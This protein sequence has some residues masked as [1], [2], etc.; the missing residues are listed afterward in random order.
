MIPSFSKT[1]GQDTPELPSTV[2]ATN[3]TDYDLR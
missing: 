3:K 2:L 1:V